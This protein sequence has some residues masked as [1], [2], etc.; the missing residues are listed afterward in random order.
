MNSIFDAIHLVYAKL[1]CGEKRI[2]DAIL[3]KA[4]VLMDMTLKELAE[5]CGCSVTTVSRFVRK[6]GLSGFLELK[7]RLFQEKNYNT[8]TMIQSP[9]E[10]EFFDISCI[11]MIM[12]A[13]PLDDSE[14]PSNL[15]YAKAK[16]KPVE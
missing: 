11:A 5:N 2:A 13:P 12:V 8:G 14:K 16:K 6:L 10:D 15:Y 3:K 9:D 4:D 7:I 1:G